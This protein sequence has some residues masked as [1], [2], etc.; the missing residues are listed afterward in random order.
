MTQP[1][2]AWNG[3][4]PLDWYQLM[5]QAEIIREHYNLGLPSVWKHI[6]RRDYRKARATLDLVVDEIRAG[7]WLSIEEIQRIRGTAP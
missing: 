7:Y 4:P 3:V 1:Q 6:N 5:H 2:S